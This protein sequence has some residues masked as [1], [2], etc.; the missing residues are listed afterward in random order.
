MPRFTKDSRRQTLAKQKQ[1]PKLSTALYQTKELIA[2]SPEITAQKLQECVS[3]VVSKV[4]R[5]I[6]KD[7]ST[8]EKELRLVKE[9]MA[10]FKSIRELDLKALELQMRSRQG[11][12]LAQVVLNLNSLPDDQL[13]QLARRVLDE[14][15]TT[16]QLDHQTSGGDGQSIHNEQSSQELQTLTVGELTDTHD[17]LPETPPSDNHTTGYS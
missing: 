8:L 7:R 1:D 12:E 5:A 11:Q 9:A 4:R 15:D 10:I 13:K 16:G 2:D 3:L 17:L 6:R 14:S